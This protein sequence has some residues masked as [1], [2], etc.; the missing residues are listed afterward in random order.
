MSNAETTQG[1]LELSAFYSMLTENINSTKQKSS[2]SCFV[3]KLPHIFFISDL[4]QKSSPS[5]L[6]HY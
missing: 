1:Q 5:T 6:S 3:F 2:K 4:E